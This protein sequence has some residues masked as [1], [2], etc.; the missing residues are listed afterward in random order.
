MYPETNK[1]DCTQTAINAMKAPMRIMRSTEARF[2]T[3]LEML[4]PMANPVGT[5]A[6]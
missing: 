6:K 5:I 4:V 2:P 1:L 3:R